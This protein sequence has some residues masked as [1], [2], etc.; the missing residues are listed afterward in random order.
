MPEVIRIAPGQLSDCLTLRA[1]SALEGCTEVDGDDAGVFIARRWPSLSSGEELLWQVLAWLNGASERPTE[2][3]LRAG[4][5][6]TNYAA[7]MA[8]VSVGSGVSL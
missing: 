8:A 7:A 3:D 4:L 6:D 1:S 2:M 5:D